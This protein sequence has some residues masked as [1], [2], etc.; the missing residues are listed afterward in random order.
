M[1]TDWRIRNIHHRPHEALG[2]VPQVKYRL[3]KL[4]NLCLRVVQEFAW[5]SVSVTA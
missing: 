3:T 4:P 5:A 1:A 2:S